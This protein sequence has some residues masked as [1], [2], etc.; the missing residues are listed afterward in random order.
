[1][2]LE[3]IQ[4]QSLQKIELLDP[5]PGE[6]PGTASTSLLAG[7]MILHFDHAALVC[8][9]PLR[10]MRCQSGTTIA[11][12]D[13]IGMASLGYRITLTKPEDCSQWHPA[14][15]CKE[16]IRPAQWLAGTI[17]DRSAVH[18]LLHAAWD[19]QREG[20]WALKLRFVGGSYCLTWRPKLDG[21]I[22]LAPE[23]QQYTIDQIVVTSPNEAFGWLHPAFAAPIVLSESSCRSAQVC[24]WPWPLR[25]ALQSHREPESYYRQTMGAALM[26]R[27]RQTLLLRQ[28][29]LALRYPV[30]V[31]GVPDGLIEEIAQALRRET[32]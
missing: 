31:K 12:P 23:G 25:R 19:Q 11:T 29:L 5:W 13:G 18:V 7:A 14:G 27:F 17:Q 3:D 26:A 9:S 30:Q 10:F 16:V 8:T 1:M 22:E 20:A 24:D 6:V 32:D 15:L 28:R 21:C 2:L 4:L